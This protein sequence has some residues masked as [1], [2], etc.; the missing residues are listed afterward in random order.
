M[1][2]WRPVHGYPAYEASS[3]G[4]VRRV[5]NGPNTGVGRVLRIFWHTKGYGFVTLSQGTKATR[6]TLGVHKVVALAF[7]GPCPDGYE[8][9]HKDH[10]PTNNVPTNLMYATHL[11]NMRQSQGYI[12]R[13][14]GAAHWRR[15]ATHC[16]HGHPFD[17]E[18]TVWRGTTRDCRT[19]HRQQ[20]QA[21]RQ[22]QKEA[23]A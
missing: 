15:K 11:E 14:R 16:K 23:V 7:L 13:H 22:R 10:T 1:E 6:C 21:Y 5:I 19:C 4:R 12:T 9:A 17:A 3:L 20:G 2:E 18:N 8:A